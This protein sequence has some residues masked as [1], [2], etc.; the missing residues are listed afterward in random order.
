MRAFLCIVGGV[1]F[2]IAVAG[3][4][5]VRLYL[6]PG[7]EELDGLYYEFEEGHPAY[8]RYQHWYRV[9]LWIG[10]VALLLLFAGIAV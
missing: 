3:Q 4:I 9:T 2:L 1:L 7:P 8:R 10:T 6:K 5:V